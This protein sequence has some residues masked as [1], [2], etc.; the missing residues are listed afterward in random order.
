MIELP[1][2]F[3][4]GLLGSSHCLG[5][6]GG[7]ALVVG[8]GAVGL[9]NN[10]T[11]QLVYTLGRIFTYACAG[12][13]AGFA[14]FW[15]KQHLATIGRAQSVV[16]IVAGVLLVWQGLLATGV[17][18]R[19]RSI[20]GGGCLAAS[21]F[22]TLL[23]SPHLGHVFLAG[24]FTGFLPCGLV[25]AYLTLA[26]GTG[27]L[28]RSVAVMTLFGLGTAPLMILAGSGASLINLQSRARLLRLAAWCVVVT[29]LISLGRGVAGLWL[30]APG[31]C[32]LCG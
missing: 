17:L 15:L 5:M 27:E 8:G 21:P 23:G 28:A 13:I 19:R 2:V 22:R 9:R 11:R 7:F 20:G 25:Y 1:L 6:C 16:A 14:G 30:A 12:G 32:P 26:L 31:E 29:G 10:V 4:G 3:L 24:L 18:P